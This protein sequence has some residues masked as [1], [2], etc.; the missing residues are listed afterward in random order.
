MSMLYEVIT[1]SRM[2]F[3]P[4]NAVK[5]SIRIQ[6]RSP[7]CF[8]FSEKSRDKNLQDFWRFCTTWPSLSQGL[9]SSSRHFENSSLRRPWGRGCS[10]EICWKRNVILVLIIKNY[11][12]IAAQTSAM[13][14]IRHDDHLIHKKVPRR[15]RNNK[16]K[17]RMPQYIL[18][19]KNL[20]VSRQ[21]TDH[22]NKRSCDSRN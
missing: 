4:S 13:F 5:E 22:C 17:L 1:A 16:M 9:L 19:Y 14:Y 6:P 15:D 2:K 10:F 8:G 21:D 18:H 11:N 3:T 12:W 7:F 20:G